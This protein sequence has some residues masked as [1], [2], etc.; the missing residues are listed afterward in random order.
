MEFLGSLVNSINLSLI[1]PREK[2]KKDSIQM[3]G[4]TGNLSHYCKRIVKI[5]GP[6]VL[7]QT[8]SFSGTPSLSISSASKNLCPQ[9]SQIVRGSSPS[10]LRVPPGST[11]VERQSSCMERESPVPP[12]NR[13]G[14]IDRCPPFKDG[15]LTSKGCQQEADGFPRKP[16][17][18]LIV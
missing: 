17:T 2:N 14:H 16:H 15:E 3:P 6:P 5:P 13:F 8:G 1:I 12:I 18:T 7:I 9:I 11:L 4:T 10:R